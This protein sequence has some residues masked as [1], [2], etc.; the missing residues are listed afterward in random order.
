MQLTR[1]T[2]IPLTLCLVLPLCRGTPVFAALGASSTTVEQDRERLNASHR[3]E[4]RAGYTV[5]ILEAPDATVREYTS[6]AG[7]VFGLAWNHQTGL[8][9]LQ[10]L[11]GPY[12]AEYS[13]ALADQSPPHRRAHR[14]T[15]E[16]LIVEKGGRM[17]AVWGRVWVRPLVPP[18]VS[19]DH[20]Q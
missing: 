11:F 5:H 10:T 2:I 16:H 1:R 7:V 4:P 19:E 14:I 17:G 20:I 6:P 12:Y 18:G 13:H 9:D 15:T 3:T 8:L